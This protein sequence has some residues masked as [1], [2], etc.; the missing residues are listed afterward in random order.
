M[1]LTTE[2]L[3]KHDAGGYTVI[4][5]VTAADLPPRATHANPRE[6]VVVG[7]RKFWIKATAQR[8]LSA[9]LIAGRLGQAT[10]AGPG[11][12]IVRVRPN[13]LPD[14]EKYSHLPQGTLVF[15]SASIDRGMNLR[16]LGLFLEDS[17]LP[18]DAVTASSRALTVAFQTWLGVGDTQLMVQLHSGRLYSIDHGEC[19]GTLDASADFSPVVLDI[20]GAPP[21]LGKEPNAVSR[22]IDQIEAITDERIGAAVSAMPDDDQWNASLERRLAI[23]TC[24]MARRDKIRGV[25]ETWSSS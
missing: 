12:A 4:D 22:A 17:K 6:V 15:G 23:A 24:L 19:F 11:A 1:P 25:M 21:D 10:G 18:A 5:V 14:D 3:E 20:P 9:E 8:G 13:A 16:D 2:D 7:G